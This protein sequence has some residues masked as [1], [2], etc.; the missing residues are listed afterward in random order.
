M[1]PATATVAHRRWRS[2]RK[3]VDLYMARE[4]DK[5]KFMCIKSLRMWRVGEQAAEAT[6]AAAATST[7]GKPSGIMPFC[8]AKDLFIRRRE[9]EREWEMIYYIFS[10]KTMISP[11]HKSL[12]SKPNWLCSME[13][14][15]Q[16]EANQTTHRL[17]VWLA[18]WLTTHIWTHFHRDRPT[19]SR[20]CVRDCVMNAM[21]HTKLGI[22]C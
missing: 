20:A 21:R 2:T 13:I 16:T 10:M 9:W 7:D 5:Y 6:P 12:S 15:R 8:I 22:N 4:Y 18:G 11:I 17:C 14:D 19:A 1:Q 3:Q